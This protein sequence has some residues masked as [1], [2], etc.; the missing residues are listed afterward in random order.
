MHAWH[1]ASVPAKVTSSGS[2]CFGKERDGHTASAARAR[3][4]MPQLLL[5]ISKSHF[6]CSLSPRLLPFGG[7]IPKEWDLELEYSQSQEQ[8]LAQ[9]LCVDVQEKGLTV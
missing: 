7:G 2:H 5:Y 8:T 4:F 1:L 9:A 6:E 3:V